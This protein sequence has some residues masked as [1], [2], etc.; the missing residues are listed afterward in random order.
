M[1]STTSGSATANSSGGSGS[2]G[3]GARS[4]ETIQ[5]LLQA[6]SDAAE[7]INRARREREER[8]RQAATEA[9]SEVAAYRKGK[10]Q[11]YQRALREG[12]GSSEDTAKTLQE[13]ADAEVSQTR[14]AAEK[15][16]GQV[17]DVLQQ[18]V[19]FCD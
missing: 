17:A 7:K 2:T 19:E 9:D 4:S 12:D 16:R 5:A 10:E 8:V 1:A 14:E 15:R 3:G 11:E 13:Q 6:E 18:C